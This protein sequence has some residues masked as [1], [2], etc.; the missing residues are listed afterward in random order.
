[1]VTAI[2]PK[3]EMISIEMDDGTPLYF[4]W[5]KRSDGAIE[6]DKNVKADATA[7]DKFDT[8]ETHVIVYYFGD[9]DVRTAVAL[10]DL[11]KGPVEKKTGAVVKFNKHDRLLTLK[12]SEG[13][14]ESIHIDSKT[15]A[16]T[17]IGVATNFKFDYAKGDR[18]RVTSA[19]V[20]GI[21][22]ALLIAPP[23]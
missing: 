11:G 6:F 1:M 4:H 9:G 23:N 14:E 5:V 19:T 3:V 10:H 17:S 13:T 22:T 12:N 2:H 16:D 18:V 20:N 21:S 8:G 15:V 7:V